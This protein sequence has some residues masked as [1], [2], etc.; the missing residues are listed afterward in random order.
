MVLAPIAGRMSDRVGGK[1][2]LMA[3]LTCFG[4]GATIIAVTAQVGTS[5]QSL[6]PGTLVL[7][8]GFGGIF[9]P[10]ATETMRSVE[11]RMAGAASGVNNTIRQVGSVVGSAA[12]GAVLQARLATTL[13]QEAVT[14]SA[15]LPASARGQF[16]AGIAKTAKG[17]IDVGSSQKATAPKG[18][19]ADLA[20]QLDRIGTA[21]F[22]H[23][24]VRAMHP[25]LIL[26]IAAMF[27]AAALC[28]LVTRHTNAPAGGRPAATPAAEPAAVGEAS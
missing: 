3:G 15:Q 25:T 12:V 20:A 18:I 4:L 26:P 6:L 28:L 2:I 13:H 24:Y 22:E 8:L 11:P 1:Y 23:G 9:A 17:G 5:W 21:V 27:A 19:A 7:G 10:M 14:R 16:L